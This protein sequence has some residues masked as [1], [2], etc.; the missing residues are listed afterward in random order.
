VLEIWTASELFENVEIRSILG[1]I[2][3]NLI[4]EQ[5]VKKCETRFSA[6]V[7]TGTVVGVCVEWTASDVP[8]DAVCAERSEEL[9]PLQTDKNCYFFSIQ[10]SPISQERCFL[11]GSQVSTVSSP[12][13]E[14]HASADV[15]GTLME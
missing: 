10:R 7:G 15:N 2:L 6:S 12:G 1:T 8:D 9:S 14:Q 4:S 13:E 3:T 5:E 11:E